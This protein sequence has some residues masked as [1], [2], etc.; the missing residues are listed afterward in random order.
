M[1]FTMYGATYGR[2]RVQEPGDPHVRVREVRAF[3][4]ASELEQL[5]EGLGARPTTVDMTWGK[6]AYLY[7]RSVCRH[8]L[9]LRCN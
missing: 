8:F 7:T 1:P 6:A 9:S 5:E 4:F 2:Q 3:L